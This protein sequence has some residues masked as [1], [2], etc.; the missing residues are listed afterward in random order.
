VQ[1]GRL[2]AGEYPCDPQSR[3][4]VERL[5]GLLACG[6]DYF[7]DLTEPGELAAYLPL[8]EQLAAARGRQVAY[9][10]FPIPDYGVPT[11]GGMQAIL[12]EIEAALAAGRCIYLHCWGGSGRTGTLVGCYLR[13]AGLDGPAALAELTRLRQVIP[14]EMRRPS[15]ETEEQAQMV[16]DWR[17][18]ST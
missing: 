12:A 2:L 18:V 3:L 1:P 9:R 15:P 14:A 13:Q 10:R 6:I 4:A 16:L 7:L 17:G 8:L 11:L 5:S